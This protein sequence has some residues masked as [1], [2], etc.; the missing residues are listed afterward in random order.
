MSNWHT[1]VYSTREIARAAGLPLERV[2]AAGN[3]ALRGAKQALFEEAAFWDAVASR[4][5]HVSLNEDPAFQDIYAEE[6]QFPR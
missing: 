6:M 3:T 4:V 5:T 1:E 2:V